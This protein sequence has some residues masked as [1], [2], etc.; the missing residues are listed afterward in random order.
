MKHRIM[1]AA[2]AA[3]CAALF[4]SSFA[5]AA[6]TVLGNGLAEDCFQ[7]AEYGGDPANGVQT[8]TLALEQ[9]ALSVR[10]R[11]ATYINRGILRARAGDSDA[12]LG[13]YD[14]GLRTDGDLAEGYV[15]RGATLIALKRYDEAYTAINKGIEMGCKRPHIAYYDR[16]IVDEAQ[17]NIRGAY[18]DYQKAVEL[19]PDFTLATEQLQRF[20][21]VR[22]QADGN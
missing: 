18:E 8:C 5:Q 21:V 1:T 11:A 15:D 14:E 2:L 20:K 22:K 4:S 13:D 3:G 6:V 7:V 19:Q 12:A 10:D 17:G 9:T 16:A